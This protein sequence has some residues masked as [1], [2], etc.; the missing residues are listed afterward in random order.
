MRTDTLKGIIS[1]GASII[2]TTA[3][4]GQNWWYW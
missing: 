2:E 1:A 4:D 3:N